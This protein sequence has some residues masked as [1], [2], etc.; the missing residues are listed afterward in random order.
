MHISRLIPTVPLRVSLS[1]L[2]G[3]WFEF[4][5]CCKSEVVPDLLF[6]EFCALN[7]KSQNLKFQFFKK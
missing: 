5:F 1:L 7:F 2:Y 4:C 6:I 3:L